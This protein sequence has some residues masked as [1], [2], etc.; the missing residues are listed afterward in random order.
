MKVEFFAS[1]PRRKARTHLD[2][3]LSRGADQLAVACAFCT[4]AGVELLKRHADRLKAEDSFLVVAS[5]KPTDHTALA[6]LDRLIHGHLFLHWGAQ[7]PVEL[8][9]GP[10][11]MHSKVFFARTGSDCWLW[12]GSHNLTGS[13]T[14]GANCEAAVL[15]Q[16]HVTEQ[17]FVD[18]LKHLTICRDEA[19]IFSPDTLPHGEWERIDMVAIHAEA[20][21]LPG[22]AWPWHVRL[23]LS[24][25]IYDWLLR[26][27]A[28][29]H[30]FLYESGAL[31]FGWAKAEP[32]AAY[33]GSLTALNFTGIHPKTK[34]IPADWSAASYAITEANSGILH[35]VPPYAPAREVTTQAVIN[36]EGISNRRDA[37]LSET[38]KIES[39]MEPGEPTFT[40]LDPDMA[41]FFRKDSREGGALVYTPIRETRRVLRLP[42]HEV[43]PRDLDNIAALMPWKPE[44]PSQIAYESGSQSLQ[45]HPFIVRAKCR[46]RGR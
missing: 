15:L 30:L 44:E 14:Q 29:V 35:L 41:R 22:G 28:D 3:V 25:A 37:L 31:R 34:G 40:R 36:I 5:E 2:E 16:G 42:E 23:G 9:V 10:A 45:R 20:A 12:T 32:I 27:P 11:I 26:P 4:A 43:R 38:P 39:R 7:T 46:I 8:K 18:A 24:T 6:D 1:D 13:A 17:V 33:A 19:R 21:V